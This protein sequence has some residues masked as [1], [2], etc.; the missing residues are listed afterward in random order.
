MEMHLFEVTAAD[1]EIKV[2][3]K[4]VPPMFDFKVTFWI[5]YLLNSLL[6]E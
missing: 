2:W 3:E 1:N 4:D 6:T 5:V